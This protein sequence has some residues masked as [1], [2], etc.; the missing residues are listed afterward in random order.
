LPKKQKNFDKTLH[1]VTATILSVNTCHTN[2]FNN[3]LYNSKIKKT[4]IANFDGVFASNAKTL[5]KPTLEKLI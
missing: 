5:T 4:N 1:N 2:Q 3:K